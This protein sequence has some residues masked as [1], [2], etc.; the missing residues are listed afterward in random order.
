MEI[1]SWEPG[2]NGR[3]IKDVLP[4]HAFFVDGMDDAKL[5]GYVAPAAV[6]VASPP[7]PVAAPPAAAPQP[8][9]PQQP[10]AGM[11]FEDFLKQ[12]GQGN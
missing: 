7:A 12:Q 2:D 5:N 8:A 1:V 11:S 10:G 9:A 4:E 6:A 3:E